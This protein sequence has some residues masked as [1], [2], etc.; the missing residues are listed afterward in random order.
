MTSSWRCSW[1][2]TYEW[3][4][5]VFLYTLGQSDQSKIQCCHSPK[6]NISSNFHSIR[7]VRWQGEKIR[8]L[9]LGQPTFVIL[10]RKKWSLGLF[11]WIC[12]QSDYK[13]FIFGK[14]SLKQPRPLRKSIEQSMEKVGFEPWNLT[15]TLWDC[16]TYLPI[17]MGTEL[18]IVKVLINLAVATFKSHYLFVN[19]SRPHF[20]NLL[21]RP[22]CDLFVINL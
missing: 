18:R 4:H 7:I 10:H 2:F 16:P 17:Y 15:Y 13:R 11:Q 5:L 9:L 14:N 19:H 22:T 3:A 6:Q 8:N 12:E 21:E 20:S 1:L